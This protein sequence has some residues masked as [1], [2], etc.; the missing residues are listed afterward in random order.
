MSTLNRIRNLDELWE[1]TSLLH[2]KHYPDSA[3]EPIMGGG[4]LHNPNCMFVFINPT[5]RNIS[6]DSSWVGQRRP[7]TGTKYIWKIFHEAGHFDKALLEEVNSK[8]EWD[9]RFADK[10]YTHLADRGFYFTNVVKWTGENANLPRA[11][12]INLFLPILKREI[13]VVNPRKIIAFGQIPFKALTKEKIRLKDYYSEVMESG[14]LHTFKTKT[15]EKAYDVI[16]CY[17]PVG[18]GNP[19]RAIDLLKFLDL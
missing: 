15:S 3:L 4:K 19:K 11:Q 8:N 6:S 1:Y 7:W 16:P 13:E 12:K 18:R 9:C 14:K 5:Y 2:S 17:F 10:V